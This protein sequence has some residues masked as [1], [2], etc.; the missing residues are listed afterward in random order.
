M[1]LRVAWVF[2]AI[3]AITL[4]SDAQA[5]SLRG[6]YFVVMW[7]YQGPTNAAIDAHSFAT[8]Y[9]GIGRGVSS[10]ATISWLPA[11]GIVRDR[12]P[13]RGKNFSLGATLRLARRHRRT[14][15]AFGPYEIEPKIY[16]RAHG[17]IR[18]LNS[19]KLA[20]TMINGPPNAVN[21]ILAVSAVGGPLSTGWS[22][23]FAA[24][25]QVAQHLSSA[26]PKV[27]PRAAAVIRVKR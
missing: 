16:Q 27:D 17:R 26:Y 18:Q 14:V 21:C 20:Y 11:T 25:R 2:A 13:E 24:S 19:G 10:P 12:G 8:F 15:R 22:W 9:R 5:Q 4:S 7:G 23:G 1:S 3:C 6:R